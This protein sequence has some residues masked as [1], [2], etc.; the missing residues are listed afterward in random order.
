M[1]SSALS[2]TN[3]AHDVFSAHSD[4]HS[5]WRLQRSLGRTQAM[6]VLALEYLRLSDKHSLSS[7]VDNRHI[8]RSV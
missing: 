1:T 8:R 2:R 7:F 3:T 5:P 4:E 6:T